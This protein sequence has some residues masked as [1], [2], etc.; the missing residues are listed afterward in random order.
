MKTEQVVSKMTIP[1]HVKFK[2]ILGFNWFNDRHA[3][4]LE[5]LVYNAQVGSILHLKAEEPR[6]CHLRPPLE[7]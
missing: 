5:V 1:T 7:G 3:L 6:A 2:D 4:I